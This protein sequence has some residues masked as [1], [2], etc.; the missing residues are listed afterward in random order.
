[1]PP[2]HPHPP[3]SNYHNIFNTYLN[4]FIFFI[5][6]IL[7]LMTCN[8]AAKWGVPRLTLQNCLKDKTGILKGKGSNKLVLGRAKTK[9]V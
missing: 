7:Y 9:S 1:M 4:Y 6:F 5:H 2:S 3:T 8:A